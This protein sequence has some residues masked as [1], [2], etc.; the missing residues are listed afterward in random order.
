MLNWCNRDSEVHAINHNES[1][2]D[3]GSFSFSLAARRLL[4]EINVVLF[5]SKK[6]C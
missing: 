2:T 3:E 1:N 4:R 6:F 5:E